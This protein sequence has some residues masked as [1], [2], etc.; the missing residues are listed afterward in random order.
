AADYFTQTLAVWRNINDPV[1]E[2][3]ALRKLGMI[4]SLQGSKK[5]ALANLEQAITLTKTVAAPEFRAALLSHIGLVYNS[6]SDYRQ[7]LDY[8]QQALALNRSAG[9]V[10][11]ISSALTSIG[12]T[13]ESQGDFQQA[14]GFYRQAID[15]RE[16]MRSAA[17][18]EELQL[19]IAGQTANIYQYAI[20]LCVQLNHT[21]QA[22]DLSESARARSLLD[23][24][25][26]ARISPLGTTD[27]QLLQQEQTLRAEISTLERQ[28]MDERDT[29]Q[30]GT[31]TSPAK[32]QIQLN[33]LQAKYDELLTRLK[34]T[35]PEYVAMR[36]VAPL[37]L[38]EIQRLLD[39]DTT[40]LSYFTTFDKTFAFII[41]R[42]SFHAVSLPVRESELRVAVQTFRSFASL[43]DLHPQELRR[44]HGW[45]IKPIK[46]YLK[47]EAVS[48]IPHGVLNYLPF[49]TLTD[50]Q[51][52]FGDEHRLSY[53]P[54]ASVLPF[55]QQK[56]KLSGGNLLALAQSSPP[57]LPVLQYADSMTAEIAKLYNSTPLHGSAATESVLHARASDSNILFLAAHAN[58]NSISP[59]F[60]RIFLS[61]DKVNDGLLEV[62]EVYRLNLNNTD[63]VV[64]S[65]CQTSVGRHSSGDDIIGLN[66]AFIYA[67]TPTVV[68][69]L[70]SVK[71]LPTGELMTVFFKNLRQGMSKAAALQAAQSKTREKYRHPYY[72]G[73]FV[74]TGD[75]GEKHARAA[76]R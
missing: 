60:S 62:H 20:K 32:R 14:L 63:L 42:D 50:G 18:V 29:A 11:G 46:P 74:L 58:L 33:T 51:R 30:P 47:T 27:P 17:R 1:S 39:K 34:V 4:Y 64:L 16:R 41:T 49:A 69:S 66:R 61:P 38:A 44:L 70:W 13:Y 28:A 9:N 24:L 2:S 22:F 76:G 12:S 67:G 54:S 40:L 71:D 21:A 43:D 45:L 68:A 57:G 15:V 59:L 35:N 75:P 72:W 48:V 65:A 6:L 73:A 53:L 56:R 26:N 37:T 55:I 23:Q 8:H 10:Q 52:Y 5:E 3:R 25:G 7:A 36:T 31:E 19:G